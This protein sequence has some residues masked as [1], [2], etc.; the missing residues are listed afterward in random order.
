MSRNNAT[1]HSD[2]KNPSAH[3]HCRLLCCCFK[4]H[5]ISSLKIFFLLAPFA[6]G[7]RRTME[8]QQATATSWLRDQWLPM[9][10]CNHWPCRQQLLRN[11]P[12]IGGR[13]RRPRAAPASHLHGGQAYSVPPADHQYGAGE[14]RCRQAPWAADDGF[15]T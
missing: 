11:L 10:G 8:M 4:I 3:S 14:F 15:R 6:L 5:G 12:A 2:A 9:P 7:D 13:H 1:Q